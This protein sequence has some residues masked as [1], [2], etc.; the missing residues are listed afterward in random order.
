[1]GRKES[2][3][4]R[5]PHLTQDTTWESDK[6]IIKHH[7]QEANRLQRTDKKTRNTINKNDPQK[8][9]RI[10][11]VSKNNFTGGLKLNYSKFERDHFFPSKL[12]L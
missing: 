9:H 11:T 12:A 3:K 10:G 5:N 6:N 4:Q 1:M 2:N 8:K 7:T